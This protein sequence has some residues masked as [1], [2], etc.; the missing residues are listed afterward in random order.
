M[1]Q[2]ALEEHKP[3]VAH[4]VDVPVRVEQ[5]GAVRR[6]KDV[7]LLRE[8]EGG[9][10]GDGDGEIGPGA[11]KGAL[12]DDGER[13]LLGVLLGRALLLLVGA[14][15]LLLGLALLSAAAAVVAAAAAVAFAA[16]AAVSWLLCLE[17]LLALSSCR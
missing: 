9:A 3:A 12:G 2:I 8:G 15:L 11:V 5:G 14:L 6:A 17:R 7:G 16:A 1:P 10:Q 13:L 4:L